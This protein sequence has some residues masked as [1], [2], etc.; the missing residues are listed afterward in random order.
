MNE[1]IKA[2]AAQAADELVTKIYDSQEKLLAAI[3]E[4][5][6]AN[7][8]KDICP[9]FPISF[10]IRL[11]WDANKA[12]Y[13]LSF[14]QKYKDESARDLPDQNQLNLPGIA[15]NSGDDSGDDSSENGELSQSVSKSLDKM[16]QVLGSGN[17]ITITAG[18]RS[19]EISGINPNVEK[20]GK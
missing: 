11:D 7:Q 9:P 2:I 12:V 4:H 18:D 19:V 5:I 3:N 13:A 16:R 15:S 20:G 17:S 1:K 10:T 8:E 14:T 6:A